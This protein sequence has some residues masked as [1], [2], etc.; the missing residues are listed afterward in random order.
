MPFLPPN[1]QCQSTVF[2]K[3]YT[4]LAVLHLNLIQQTDINIENKIVSG[5]CLV[6]IIMCAYF[7]CICELYMDD[8]VR[9]VTF[10]GVKSKSPS[11]WYQKADIK[12]IFLI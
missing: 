12:E 11:H 7:V 9:G 3:Q 4:S 8:E 10:N 2:V 1:Q 6:F 5:L